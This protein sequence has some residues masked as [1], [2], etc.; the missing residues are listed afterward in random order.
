[1]LLNFQRDN[2]HK[3]VYN[4]TFSFQGSNI[5]MDTISGELTRFLYVS[6]NAFNCLWLREFTRNRNHVPW[7]AGPHVLTAASIF[8]WAYS[9]KSYSTKLSDNF[10]WKCKISFTCARFIIQLGYKLIAE[11]Y[12]NQNC[13]FTDLCITK[14]EN[15]P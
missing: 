1:M 8:L 15:T 13:D 5:F 7:S 14:L 2:Y 3:F 4:L 12:N 11:M 6:W 9:V 10:Q